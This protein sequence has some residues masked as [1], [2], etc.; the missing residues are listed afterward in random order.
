LNPLDCFAMIT[1]ITAKC[2]RGIECNGGWN[3]RSGRFS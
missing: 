3:A 1:A 2:H